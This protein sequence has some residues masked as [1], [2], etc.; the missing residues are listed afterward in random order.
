[1]R[2]KKFHSSPFRY[3]NKVVLR[4]VD[5]ERSIGFYQ[6]MMGLKILWEEKGRVGLSADGVQP[7]LELVRPE[8]AIPK[9]PRRTGLYHYALLLPHRSQLG[10]FLKHMRDNNYPIIGG[11]N[12][13]V[14]EAVYLQ[15]PD[16]H[17]I[18]VYVDTDSRNWK[19]E[20]GQV[21][22]VTHPLDY[23]GLL[24]EAG[25]GHWTGMPKETIIGHIHLHVANLNDAKAFYMDG[26]GFDLVMELGGSALF[27]SSGGYHHHIGLNIWNGVGAAPLPKNAA[28]LAYY[29]LL[30][31][32][33]QAR[34]DTIARLRERKDPVMEKD[35][36]FYTKDP[37]GNVIR[38]LIP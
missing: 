10:L 29:T 15:D 3:I 18:E 20:G 21:D 14:S 27:L 19:W 12:H 22:M 38:L 33:D 26:L 23:S 30:F 11:S 1:M 31:P 5:L 35:G 2:M 28:G 25:D 8:D 4:V 6:K 17:G 24:E 16:D 34:R 13:G 36:E 37:S 32:D 7:L 9:Q